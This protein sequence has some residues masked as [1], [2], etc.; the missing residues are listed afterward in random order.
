[1]RA[2]SKLSVILVATFVALL[3]IAIPAVAFRA[4][5]LWE[6]SMLP[7]Q[8]YY[9]AME[10]ACARNEAATKTFTEQLARYQKLWEAKP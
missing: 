3:C 10:A 5:Q 7:K 1:M 9:V 2:M 8:S 4:G 6:L